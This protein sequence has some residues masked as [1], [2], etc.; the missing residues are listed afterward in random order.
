VRAVLASWWG[1]MYSPSAIRQDVVDIA[2][3]CQ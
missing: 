1:P 2:L 3:K